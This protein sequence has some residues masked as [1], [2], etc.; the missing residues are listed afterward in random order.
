MAHE[1]IGGPVE[2]DR[3][4]GLE[5]R[6]QQFAEGAAFAQPAPGR[7]L[8]AWS[9]HASDQ[10]AGDRIALDAIEAKSRE[11]PIDPQP[12]HGGETGGFD[13]NRA[14][15]GELQGGDVNLGVDWDRRDGSGRTRDRRGH[16]RRRRRGGCFAGTR[17]GSDEAGGEA[18]SENLNGFRLRQQAGLAGEQRVDTGTQAWPVGLRQIEMPAEVEQADLADL[19]AGALGGDE[20]EGEV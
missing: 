4:H 12:F 3:R 9:G 18:L 19:A 14:R 20:T 10:Q 5:V 1:Q 15:P 6:V 16:V 7:H 8:A 2:P 13:P 17:M 11:D